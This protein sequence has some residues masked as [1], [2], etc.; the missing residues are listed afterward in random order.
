VRESMG[1]WKTCENREGREKGKGHM[2]GER[3]RES[4]EPPN[5]LTFPT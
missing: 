1:E 5:E 4:R 3:T 2:N